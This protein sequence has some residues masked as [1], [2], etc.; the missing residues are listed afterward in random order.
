M[1]LK[2]LDFSKFKKSDIILITILTILFIYIFIE[3]FVFA[4]SFDIIQLRNIDDYSFNIS[5][6]QWHNQLCNL[7]ISKLLNMNDY[8]YGWIF[9]TIHGIITFPFYL[10]HNEPLMIS[11]ARNISL[12]FSFGTLFL[13][14][15]ILCNYT[16]NNFYKTLIILSVASAQT[17]AL[18]AQGFDNP[19]QIMFF[20]TLGVYLL[21]KD[22][23]LSVKT[24]IYSALAVAVAV[25]TKLTGFF[26]V[27]L[28]AMLLLDKLEFKLNKQN[29]KKI[30]LYVVVFTIAAIIFTNPGL[31]LFFLY[32]D[33]ISRYF[34][35]MSFCFGQYHVNNNLPVN[36]MSSLKNDFGYSF[37]GLFAFFS[38]IVLF[39]IKIVDDFK[40]KKYHFLY[41]LITIILTAIILIY[42]VKPGSNFVSRYFTV[43]AVF[44][45][46]SLLALEKFKKTGSII[47][48]I[49]FI[50]IFYNANI[51]LKSFR[52]DR[53]IL[54]R[55]YYNLYFNLK[56][57][58]YIKHNLSTIS[59]LKKLIPY[60]K[61][62][63]ITFI[64]E[65]RTVPPY[66]V[67][68]D[69]IKVFMITENLTNIPQGAVVN[70]IIIRKDTPVI[71]REISDKKIIENLMLNNIYNRNKYKLLYEK[72]DV[73]AYKKV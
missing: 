44:L 29:L 30:T 68:R 60:N 12:C 54:G 64:C 34:I 20:A 58:A 6:N 17:F 47:A 24:L 62:T 57:S 48:I 45:P 2:L 14:Y 10:I 61:N 18:Y 31:M 26:I 42:S 72:Y 70:Y 55:T 73:M 21:L 69:N 46:F 25:G 8:G 63:K 59:D 7:N 41:Y 49:I 35:T 37:Y 11:T 52:S 23:I 32:K 9:W 22:K 5:L 16:Q 51:K 19:A 36:I 71:V 27:P 53:P 13:L 38:F 56:K 1:K 3:N 65:P 33:E 66:S 15:K 40:C 67:F 50:T 4:S 43:I 28:I 39:I